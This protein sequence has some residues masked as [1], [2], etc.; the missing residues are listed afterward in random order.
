MDKVSSRNNNDG[1]VDKSCVSMST[2]EPVNEVMTNYNN[3]GDVDKEL[4]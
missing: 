4:C 3:D 2:W 1:D